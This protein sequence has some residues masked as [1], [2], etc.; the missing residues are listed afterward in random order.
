MTLLVASTRQMENQIQV[1]PRPT[2]NDKVETSR[3]NWP[4]PSIFQHLSTP[5]A[6]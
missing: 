2:H 5:Q 4:T 6:T 1:I 3:K